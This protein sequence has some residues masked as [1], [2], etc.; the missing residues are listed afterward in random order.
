MIATSVWMSGSSSPVSRDLALT[1]PA[2]TVLSRPNGEPIAITHSPTFSLV[3]SPMRTDG[4]PVASILTSA[5]S[6]RLSAPIDLRLELA[7]VGQRDDDLVGAL[8]D[9]GVG[10]HVA[11]GAEDEARADAARLRRRRRRRLLRPP[12]GF[13][14][15]RHRDAEAAEE[16]EHVLVDLGPP[17]P[18]PARGALGG[19]DVDHRRA[20]LL[21]QLGEVGQALGAR[22]ARRAEATRPSDSA[23]RRGRW[24]ASRDERGERK[25]SC[26]RSVRRS[27][28]MSQQRTKCAASRP[29]ARC[30]ASC[31]RA[32]RRKVSAS[33]AACHRPP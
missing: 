31:A 6:V 2:V 3:E 12:R 18:R 7:L 10:H 20:D 5:T 11:V 33:R 28:E 22:R 29:T 9:V 30:Y 1:M 23:T 4:R 24:R 27:S 25:L 15:V 16:L 32:Q 14:P 17:P 21:D 26:M 8:D 19:A 13:G